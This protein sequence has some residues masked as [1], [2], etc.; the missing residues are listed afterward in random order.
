[1]KS[2]KFN[3]LLAS[4]ALGLVLLLGTHAGNAQE[5]LAQQSDNQ[6]SYRC[7]NAGYRFASAADREGH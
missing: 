1:M 7:P 5:A 3:S 2:V 6:I 4:T